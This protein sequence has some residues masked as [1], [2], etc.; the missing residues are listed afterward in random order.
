MS[1]IVHHNKTKNNWSIG[2][3]WT[4]KVWEKRWNR[5]YSRDQIS[6]KCSIGRIQ[7]TAAHGGGSNLLIYTT[8]G[9][10]Y[11]LVWSNFLKPFSGVQYGNALYA[12]HQ[13]DARAFTGKH[14]IGQY[15]NVHVC[16]RCMC[17]H[18]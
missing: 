10:E 15:N 7:V 11:E 2:S 13:I 3:S 16:A 17:V 5:G 18:V 14:G 4:L 6:E 1:G 9:N 12:A 8:D